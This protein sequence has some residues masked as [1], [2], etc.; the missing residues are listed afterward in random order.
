MSRGMGR[1]F[2]P[3]YKDKRTGELKTA[4]TWR[5]ELWV[6]G[7]RHSGPAQTE[8][9]ANRILKR[10][11]AEAG[12]GQFIGNAAERMPYS[13]LEDLVRAD[14]KMQERKSLRRA[15]ISMVHLRAAFGTDRAVQITSERIST[16]ITARLDAG[17][18]PATVQKELAAL[19]RMYTLAVRARRLSFG[20]VPYI[21]TLN[22]QNIRTGFFEDAEYDSIR[23]HLSTDVQPVTDF[24]YWTGWRT[25]ETLG[26]QWRQVDF[27]NGVIRLDV[28]TTKNDE[29]RELPFAV[30][31]DLRAVLECQRARTEAVQRETGQII[32]WVFHRGGERIKDFLTGW[33]KACE[34][35]GLVGRVPHDFRRTAVRRY[36]RAG[37]SRSVAMK[38]TG[39]KAESVYRRYAIV[40]SADLRDGLGKVAAMAPS[41][42]PA[43]QVVAIASAHAPTAQV[44]HKARRSSVRIDR[45]D[46]P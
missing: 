36:E 34:K 21:P 42:P 30:L 16:Y 10:K 18:K 31:P 44:P 37:V 29:G 28:G 40:A 45:V 46:I 38:L 19:R 25:K 24:M 3:K 1:V 2:Q 22:I 14:Y 11:I 15:E 27:A 8:A 5:W 35:A 7:K 17:A 6:N 23:R 4:N 32:P 43:A 33:H 9:A 39:H 20:H 26:L 41:T 12:A 13:T